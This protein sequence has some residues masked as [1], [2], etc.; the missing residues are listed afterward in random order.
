MM[1]KIL[2]L[3]LVCSVTMLS[4][5]MVDGIAMVVENEPVTLSEITAVQQ[6]MQVSR[7][8]AIEILIQDRLQKS[9][10]NAIVVTEKEV[11]D[12][13]SQIAATNKVSMEQM[14]QILKE[15][16]VSWAAYRENIKTELKKQ[17]FFQEQ[18]S[19]SIPNPTD[20]ELKIF[21]SNNVSLFSL[22]QTIHMVEYKAKTK[23][24][25]QMFLQNPLGTSGVTSK[26]LVKKPSEV[27][28]SLLPLLLQTKEGSVT[29]PVNAGDSYVIYFVQAKKGVQAIDFETAKP[30]VLAQWR[31]QQKERALKDY[32]E[33]LRTRATIEM[34]R[35]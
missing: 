2:I 24:M 1:K 7:E 11:D 20:D 13:V 9:A 30:N 17:K 8:Q 6:G 14:Q 31:E 10:M 18:V 4:A 34:I 21:Y 15:Q 22:P 23:K 26:V 19:A 35:E 25:M 3:L 29:P 12:K 28:P 27:S 33:K 16:N 32:F 5:K